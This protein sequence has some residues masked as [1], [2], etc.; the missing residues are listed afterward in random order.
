[1]L[2]TV[3]NFN[4]FFDDSACTDAKHVK[5]NAFMG[6]VRNMW[7]IMWTQEWHGDP[8]QNGG[9]FVLGPGLFMF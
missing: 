3:Y 1:M 6:L 8:K 9:A 5:Q 2:I 7:K 4:I